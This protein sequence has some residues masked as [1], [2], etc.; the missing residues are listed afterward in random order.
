[1]KKRLQAMCVLLVLMLSISMFAGCGV[2]QNA[3]VDN[4]ENT[5][6]SQQAST[7][8]S[9]EEVSKTKVEL[10]FGWWGGDDRHQ[11]T[12][13][14][15]NKYM[16]LNPN[17]EIIA[18]NQGWDGYKEKLYTQLAGG[19][20]PDLFQNH[21]QWL[22]EQAQRGNITKDLFEYEDMLNLDIYQEGFLERNAIYDDKL[23]ALPISSSC[24]AIIANKTLMDEAGIDYEKEWTFEDYF[25]ANEKLKAVNPEYYFENGMAASDIHNYWFTI[26]MA[27]KEGLPFTTDYQLSYS[28]ETV[29]AAFDFIGRYFEEGVCEPLG[30]C[31]L[32]SGKYEQNPKWI[33]G[34]SAI[35]FGMLSTMANNIN[36]I[37][38][39]AIVIRPP[40][41]ADGKD[42]FYQMNVGHV[43]SLPLT[44]EG[45]KA[46]EAIKLIDWMI[47]SD[48]AAMELKLSRGI[49]ISQSQKQIL[50]DAGEISA[51]VSKAEQY[52]RDMNSKVFDD[53]LVRNNEIVEIG[54][55]MISKVAFDMITTDEATDEYIE[56]I[57][58]KLAE[59]KP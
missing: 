37:G 12:I 26:Y 44:A 45:E 55:D 6:H 43:F 51:L 5:Q 25:A 3:D 20:A 19:N 11:A 16:E 53:S 9:S 32:Y 58:K 18:E 17:I 27:Q 14:A 7:Q 31:Q 49:P 15:I 48:E 38:E 41:V 2:K 59:L 42:T 50:S 29:K 33:N 13:A 4:Q 36:A 40:V 24:Y 21:W 22:A 1:M 8:N 39:N 47:N 35:S 10:R 46:E 54:A 30:T 28:R 56:L 57:N 52:V 34:E 23:L